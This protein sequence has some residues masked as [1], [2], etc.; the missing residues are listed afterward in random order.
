MAGTGCGL[1]WCGRPGVRP[2]ASDRILQWLPP[3]AF[4][5]QSR[6]G[7]P[8]AGACG[9]TANAGLT[10]PCR[11]R[12]VILSAA[13]WE[14][15]VFGPRRSERDETAQGLRRV[16]LEGGP[17]SRPEGAGVPHR[18]GACERAKP[19]T[20]NPHGP[21]PARP[22]S[23][24]DRR[25]ERLPHA[26]GEFFARGVLAWGGGGREGQA[27]GSELSGE[28][29]SHRCGNIPPSSSSA[30]EQDKRSDVVASE[31]PFRDFSRQCDVR[32][33]HGMDPRF[34]ALG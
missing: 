5:P 6:P 16:S 7:R 3:A 33:D 19:H 34:G 10:S 15:V 32:M 12:G 28:P 27:T 18:W 23:P 11:V 1:R 25:T 31:D 13:G 8:P 21:L 2:N 20:S 22:T 17:A 29:R 24:D 30:S 9:V 14:R 26:A 4:D